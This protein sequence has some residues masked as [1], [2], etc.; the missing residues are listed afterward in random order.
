M[1]KKDFLILGA[2][3]TGLSAAKFFSNYNK[4]FDVGDTRNDP[5]GSDEITTITDEADY[6]FGKNF[7]KINTQKYH[8]FFLSPGFNIR[9][10]QIHKNRIVSELDLFISKS[11]G[12]IIVVTGT[13]GKSSTVSYISQML[14]KNKITLLVGGNYGIPMLDLLTKQTDNSCSIIE[15]SSFQLEFFQGDQT[16]SDFLRMALFLNFSPDHL[17]R[18]DN[19]HYYYLSKIKVAKLLRPND[20]LYFNG[21]DKK[22][23]IQGNFITKSF[24]N[25]LKAND[26]EIDLFNYEAAQLVSLDYMKQNGHPCKSLPKYKDLIKLPYRMEKMIINSRLSITNDSKSTNP[27]SVSFALNSLSSE[28]YIYL[29][30]GGDLKQNSFKG[31]S[32]QANIKKI[33]CYGKDASTIIDHLPQN[34]EALLMNTIDDVIKAIRDDFHINDSYEDI[35]ILFSPGCSSYDQFND[36]QARGDY[37]NEL[38]SEHLNEF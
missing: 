12:N 18:H 11:I 24:T 23:L 7:L 9:N 37:F 3:K 1:K 8:F 14:K 25:K 31:F 29:I 2:G 32:T 34:I 6:F 27:H 30:L 21:K 17:D 36:Y 22:T 4:S 16:S 19:T 20:I 5:P 28:K 13:N 33:F 10:I 35:H 26:G 15:L 38:C